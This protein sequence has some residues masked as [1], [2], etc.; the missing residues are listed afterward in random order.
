MRFDSRGRRTEVDWVSTWTIPFVGAFL[1]LG[2]THAFTEL[3]CSR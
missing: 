2:V 1:L 3:L